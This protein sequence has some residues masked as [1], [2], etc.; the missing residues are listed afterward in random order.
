MAVIQ[1]CGR[2]SAR[3]RAEALLRGKLTSAQGS[4]GRAGDGQPGR[5]RC[6]V[7]GDR[8]ARV[9]KIS[10]RRIASDHE[11]EYLRLLRDLRRSG[12]PGPGDGQGP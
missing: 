9:E 6:L 3:G 10:E 11:E 12:R 8:R 2:R 1:Q 5:S 4:A 7:R